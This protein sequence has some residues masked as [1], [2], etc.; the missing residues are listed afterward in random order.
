MVIRWTDPLGSRREPN[1]R[2]R[3]S[4]VHMLDDWLARHYRLERRLYHYDVLVPR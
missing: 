4:G 2:G 3:P 1:L